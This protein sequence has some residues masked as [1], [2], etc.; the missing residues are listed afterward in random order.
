MGG[1]HA[2]AA[3]CVWGSLL[4]SWV[5]GGQDCPPTTAQGAL[6]Q[7][8]HHREPC[9]GWS[10]LA[11]PSPAT[12]PRP[13]GLPPPILLL[14]SILP[15]GTLGCPQA[16]GTAGGCGNAAADGDS[17]MGR[18]LSPTPPCPVL[19]TANQM[20]TAC[21]G[22]RWGQ[23][24]RGHTGRWQRGHAKSGSQQDPHCAVNGGSPGQ[25]G[26]KPPRFALPGPA[27]ASSSRQPRDAAFC[28]TATRTALSPRCPPATEPPPHPPARRSASPP[29]HPRPPP[30]SPA[31][32][33][34]PGTTPIRLPGRLNRSL[35][36]TPTP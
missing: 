11:T 9:K 34:S 23:G 19:G 28:T 16:Q 13:L 8:Q 17:G 7:A 35:G 20:V 12:A 36:C 2:R 26:E 5:W 33:P 29:A 4:S 6:G 14:I 31:I 22:R 3:L 15:A 18:L 24:P 27:H 25:K 32:T 1:A 30:A 10:C 21:E